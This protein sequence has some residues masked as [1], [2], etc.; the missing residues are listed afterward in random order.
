MSTR[1][2]YQSELDRTCDL[3]F[4]P[5][6]LEGAALKGPSKWVCPVHLAFSCGVVVGLLYSLVFKLII[7]GIGALG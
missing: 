2:K 1:K 4:D 6:P 5:P 3:L 7:W